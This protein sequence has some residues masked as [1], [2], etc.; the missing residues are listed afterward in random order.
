MLLFREQDII[1]VAR[2][3]GTFIQ[4]FSVSLSK[5]LNPKLALMAALTVY[6]CWVM[7]RVVY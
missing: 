6:E 3:P 2:T 5:A 1:L 4:H 7:E